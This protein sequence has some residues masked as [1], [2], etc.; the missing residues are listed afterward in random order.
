MG[1]RRFRGPPK[2]VV[3]RLSIV[4]RQIAFAARRRWGGRR[5]LNFVGTRYGYVV[6]HARKKK[7]Q[8]APL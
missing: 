2:L 4:V 8:L 5:D 3:R 6:T 1:Y 7:L